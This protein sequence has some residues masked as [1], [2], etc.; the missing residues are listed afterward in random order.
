[1]KNCVAELPEGYVERFQL[2]LQK[3]KKT[4]ILVNLLAILIAIPLIVL[5]HF[6]V[7]VTT[8]FN[9]ADDAD[10]LLRTFGKCLVMMFCILAYIPLHELV[11]GICMKFFGCPK[12]RYGFTGL[13][14]YAGSDAYFRKRPYLVIA[15][16]P[17]VIWGIV[18]LVIN[19]LTNDSWFWVFYLVQ[20]Q[21]LSGAAGDL[22]V[23]CRFA[24]LPADLLVRD[25]GTSMTVYARE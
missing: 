24:K 7:P 16:A 4:A 11:H 17:V 21:N 13:Y 25:T 10:A 15:L 1:M 14:A 2:D 5:G 6:R 18:L 22:Y 19:C 23:S 8:V 20:V 12:V 9:L 3:N